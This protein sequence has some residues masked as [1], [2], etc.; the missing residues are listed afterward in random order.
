MEFTKNYKFLEND[1]N[2]NEIVFAYF[3][4]KKNIMNL[5]KDRRFTN[6][7]RDLF[8]KKIKQLEP[9]NKQEHTQYINFDFEQGG[10]VF[11][12]FV[13]KE[14]ET[15]DLHTSIRKNLKSAL[16][17][18]G[19]VLVNLKK[20]SKTHQAIVTDAIVS[21]RVL[22]TWV[23]P[24]Y[25][26]KT[27]DQKPISISDVIFICSQSPAIL[28]KLSIKAQILGEKNNLVRTLAAT[29]GNFLTPREYKKIVLA[30]AKDN[31]L[32]LKYLDNEKLK[33]LGAG[34]FLAVVSAD[35]KSDGGIAH[36]TYKPSSRTKNVISIV[37]KGLC[38]DTGGYNVKT[39]DYMYSMH[40]DMTGSAVAL[41][42][43][44]ALSKLKA[45]FEVH[46]YLA[47]AENHISLTG[48]KPNDVVTAMDGTTIEVVNTDAEGRMVLCDTLYYSTLV[49]PDLILDFATLTGGAIYSIGTKRA[50]IFSNRP[51]LSK[52][53][54]ECGEISGERC[55]DFPIGGDYL[56]NIKSETADILQ[57][58]NARGVDHINAASFLAHFVGSSPWIHMDLSC[59]EN[60]G[61][62]GLVS[63]DVTGFGVRW[64]LKII[65]KYFNISL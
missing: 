49:K 21:L 42:L 36:L 64:G 28:K 37:G 11:V 32:K 29:P 47:I 41:A 56:D 15:F 52:L 57:C 23:H 34:G 19:K 1:K 55:W 5:F 48:F 4:D 25:G 9:P 14:I 27:K 17:H 40:R 20:I 26:K 44:E 24:Q 33:K 3:E 7:T 50:A 2:K 16:K 60:K 59:E 46:T 10:G 62:L 43:S 54:V 12:L 45:P 38:F 58:S 13:S 30:H 6:E 65:E 53:G 18:K 8:A 51:Q 31:K 22:E 35:P 63:S 39:G 61:G